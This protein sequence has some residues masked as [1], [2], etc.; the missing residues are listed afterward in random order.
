MLF[1]NLESGEDNLF[2]L[3]RII[4]LLISFFDVVFKE[5]GY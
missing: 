4:R 5:E 1:D 2:G 3:E